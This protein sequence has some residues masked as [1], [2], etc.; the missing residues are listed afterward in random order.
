MMIEP[1]I[2]SACGRKVEFS[3]GEAPCEALTGWLSL[4]QWKGVS[5]VDHFNFCSF[6]CLKKWVNAKSPQIPRIFLESFKE[7]SGE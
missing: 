4:A 3:P 5:S 7:E 6:T 2:C 1:F